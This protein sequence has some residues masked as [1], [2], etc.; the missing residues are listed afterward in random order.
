[1]ISLMGLSSSEA[2]DYDKADVS[3]KTPEDY[4]PELTESTTQAKI[5]EKNDAAQ[6]VI[7][8]RTRMTKYN[9]EL[10]L[11]NMRIRLEETKSKIKAELD[12]N[13]KAR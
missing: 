5:I 4:K 13:K 3:E 12:D 7:I 11:G 8:R 2:L 1:M 9:A 10:R 6:E